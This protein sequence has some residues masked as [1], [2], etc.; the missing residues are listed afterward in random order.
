MTPVAALKSLKRLLVG[1]SILVDGREYI[2]QDS[3]IK[4]AMLRDKEKIFLNA[5][6]DLGFFLNYFTAQ[7]IEDYVQN[8]QIPVGWANPK[9]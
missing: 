1:E 6:F 2:Y 9:H 7:S 8:F 4:I 3:Q 5:D